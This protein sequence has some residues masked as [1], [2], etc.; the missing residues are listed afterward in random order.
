MLE[1]AIRD[2]TADD[3]WERQ[4]SGMWRMAACLWLAWIVAN[5]VGGLL[6][7][8]AGGLVTA[9][10]LAALGLLHPAGSRTS[11]EVALVLACAGAW[12][13]IAGATVA[14][15]QWAVL[16]SSHVDVGLRGWLGKNA[17]LWLVGTV[18][19]GVS[20]YLGAF[21]LS[22]PFGGALV[23]VVAGL[24][25]AVPIAIG[26]WDTLEG[27]SPDAWVWLPAVPLGY[28]ASATF[29]A[30]A[31]GA[32]MGGMRANDWVTTLILAPAVAGVVGGCVSGL[33]TGLALVWL[34]R[35]AEPADSGPARLR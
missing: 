13:L 4:G 16:R 19:A 7:F 24:V 5:A 28:A 33:V 30:A 22:G 11:L 27:H 15:A 26:Q 9:A 31:A 6:G 32:V 12:P 21:A 25:L 29:G 17:A 3:R 23:F 8:G 35:A 2:L 18:A 10:G 14:L 20:V 1:E 34:V